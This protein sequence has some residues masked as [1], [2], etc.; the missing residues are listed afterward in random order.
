VVEFFVEESFILTDEGVG[1]F[2]KIGFRLAFGLDEEFLEEDL[3]L[4]VHFGKE[5]CVSLGFDMC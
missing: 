5:E 1:D 3:G 2:E 4:V